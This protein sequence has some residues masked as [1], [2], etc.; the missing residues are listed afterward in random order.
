MG[1][2]CNYFP[3]FLILISK[4]VF[5]KDTL[6]NVISCCLFPA[7][8]SWLWTEDLCSRRE[9]RWKGKRGK[10]SQK[11]ST[12]CVV[13]HASCREAR[14]RCRR[15][16]DWVNFLGLKFWPKVIF[17]G[18]WKTLG[19]FWVPKKTRGIWV[20]KKQLTDI[21][22]Y[23]KKSS[24]F[25]GYTNSEVVIFLGIKYEPLSDTRPALPRH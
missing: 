2:P 5:C 20:A 3:R 13:Y 12:N 23:A 11:V 19:F 18:L 24:D 15:W 16:T 14:S 1:I 8:W 6:V 7:M 21:L 10:T 22:G 25:F 9:E 17:L 4:I